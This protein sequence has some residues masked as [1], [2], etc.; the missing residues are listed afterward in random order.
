[1]RSMTHR[2]P[3]RPS[4]GK[5][6][7][8][9]IRQHGRFGAGREAAHIP[10][11]AL[12]RPCVIAT[13]NRVVEWSQKSMASESH[14]V[15]P[16]VSPSQVRM[17]AFWR[18]GQARCCAQARHADKERAP[19]RWEPDE[20]RRSSPVLQAPRGSD[21]P[22]AT[23]LAGG[24]DR[25]RPADATLQAR[26]MSCVGSVSSAASSGLHSRTVVL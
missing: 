26:P 16:P 14:P 6:D 4:N 22:P 2:N 25:A 1:L 17:L 19:S 7:R 5:A 20:Q 15:M 11:V 18:S 8:C 23:L 10:R 24:F 12:T 13:A 21:F 9:C 3:T